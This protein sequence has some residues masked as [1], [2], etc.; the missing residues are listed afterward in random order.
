LAHP[1]QL[2]IS[3]LIGNDTINIMASA[4]A[5]SVAITLYGK[6]GKWL[7]IAVMTPLLLLVGEIIPKAFSY[8]KASSFCLR[9]SSFI[10]FFVYI[11]APF[12]N[13]IKYIVNAVLY[14]MPPPQKKAV[15]L[16]NQFLDLIET[17]HEKGELKPIEKEFIVRLFR[18]RQ[19]TVSEIM[20]PRPDIFALSIDTDLKE[21][22]NS[23]SY[24]RF[25]RVPIYEGI[26]DNVI[27][28][29]HTKYLLGS[30]KTGKLKK[31]RE[32]LLPPYFVP[33]TKKA[34]ALL[35]ELQSQKITMAMIVNEYGSIVGLVTTEDLLE[36]LFGEI[37]DEY[38]VTQDWYQQIAPN[39]YRVLAKIP[40]SDFNFI[41]K[42]DLKSEE[43]TLGGLILTALGRLPKK[44]DTVQIGNF[45]FTVKSLKGRRITE[46]EVEKLD[47]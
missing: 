31:F 8:A 2:L 26:L 11:V 30:E 3:I 23:L 12:R 47:S 9:I 16:E 7:A 42:T 44:E 14:F 28:I 18:F 41:F 37:Y 1:N 21:A 35:A 29:F 39:R 34:E 38:D 17:G 5:T 19:K 24:H 45:K 6:N 46:L 40:L 22:I 36:E 43:D 32:K 33:A 25:S 4:L 13:I 27:G 20:V 10:N 15:F